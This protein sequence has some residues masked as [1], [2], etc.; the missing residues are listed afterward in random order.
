M[1]TTLAQLLVHMDDSP[2]ALT[3]LALARRIAQVHGAK[4]AALYAVS[5]S[6]IE[7]P[8]APEAGPYAIELLAELDAERRGKARAAFDQ[9]MSQPGAAANWAEAEQF[10]LFP[11][12][13]EQAMCADLMVLGQYSEE[14]RVTGVPANL[15]PEVLAQSGKPAI[16]VPCDVPPPESFETIVIA[17]KPTREAARAV[18][19]ALPFLQRARKVHVLT[20]G[21]P[22]ENPKP[23]ALNLRDYLALRGVEVAW[24]DGGPE[25]ESIG[26][27]VLSSAFDVS[28]D[29]LVM[30]CYGHG[31]V[32]E[33]VLGGASRSVLGSMTLPVLMAH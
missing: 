27:A 10:P 7:T 17:W 19:A 21:E 32:R 14:H 23:P 16:V 12:V 33:W 20:W 9:A 5:P 15:V 29:L 25:P 28:A 22:S 3:R 4:V 8:L 2:Q 11:A 31:R 24:H 30:G 13:A 1:K 6:M 26:D 18:E